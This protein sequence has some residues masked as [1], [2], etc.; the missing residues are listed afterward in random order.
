MGKR[1]RGELGRERKGEL[2][3]GVREGEERRVRKW[4]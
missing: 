4:S 3:S 1:R 2:G